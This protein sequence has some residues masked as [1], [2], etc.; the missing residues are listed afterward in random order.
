MKNVHS[1]LR[2]FP[3][4]TRAGIRAALTG[5]LSFT[6]LL[7]LLPGA[8]LAYLDLSA[9][10]V[11]TLDNG[12]TVI[13][14][15]DHGFP[16][17]SVQMLYKS[18]ARD[19]ITGK[20][21]LAHFLEHMAFRSSRNF[22][23]TGVVSS[24]YAAGGEWHGY[25]WLDQTTYFATVP[26]EKL[27]L[28]LRI[29]ADRMTRLDIPLADM[30]SERGAVLTEM[31]SY[32]NDP[33]TVLQ[34]NVM[35]LSFLAHPY[36]N[37]TIGWES[38]IANITHADL[39]D[40]YHRHYQPANAV[41]AIVG[42]VQT[43]RVMQAVAQ[44]FAAIEGHAVQAASYTVEPAQKG[45]RR[46]RLKGE[47]DRKYFKIVYHA[48]GVNNPDYAAFLVT[49]DLLAAGSGVSFLQNDWGTPARAGS[50]LAGI[51]DDLSTWFPPSAQDYV[52][53][54]SGTLPANGDEHAAETAIEDG[55]ESLRREFSE[56]GTTAATALG[57]A[58]E[59]VTRELTFDL[60]TTEDA[61][62]QL[63]FFEGLDAL[64]VLVNLEKMVRQVSVEDIER[65]L[66]RY[67]PEQKR[68]VGWY[69]PTQGG[70]TTG[71]WAE[72]VAATPKTPWTGSAQDAEASRESAASPVLYTLANGTPVIIQ[73]S[74]LSP[75]AV[76]KVITP[77]ASFEL[78]DGASQGQPA[79]GLSS[80][81]FELLPAELE[82]AIRQARTTL[83]TAAPMEAQAGGAAT[84]PI[85]VLDNTFNAML[86]L[87]YPKAPARGPVLLVV[88]GD[89]DPTAVLGQLQR[90]FGD[91]TAT[92]WSPPP[93]IGI[94][95]PVEVEKYVDFPVAQEQ[96]GYLVQVPGPRDRTEPAWRMALYI[97]SH[98][99][100]GRLGKA[101]ISR[102][103][104]V[105]HIDSDW[106]TDGANDWITIR[107]GVD[108]QKLPAMKA[109]LRQELDRLIS[110]PPSAAEI[111]A[112]RSHLL[113]RFV[114]AAQSNG[115]LAAWLA[116]QW[117]LHGRLPDYEDL[118]RRL[119][120]VGRNDIVKML[121][122]FTSGSIVSVRNPPAETGE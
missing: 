103:G 29:E 60:Q 7:G 92:T 120:A 106:H 115:E 109:L 86:G 110:E 6:L 30:D 13:V 37:N 19:E 116:G 85:S 55:I 66:D 16:V 38:D 43:D 111:D 114:S 77:A 105:Y 68:T 83:E 93:A 122:A 32:E 24:I 71:P 63:A 108:P 104:L 53:M 90:G 84:D 94:L 97:L 21:G 25:T 31:H 41:L 34:D 89:I 69:V 47:V 78:P 27:D 119:D 101:A 46:I 40:F 70:E 91:M 44:N 76:F 88:T 121:P 35:Y 80:I 49:Q 36:R 11:E 8:A 51:G 100:E 57:K 17:V 1:R 64:G 33:A 4:H 23:D 62:H 81:D 117:I 98:G 118:K 9:A 56:A 79:W 12:L 95:A 54:I 42:D 65:V 22:P 28:L 82:R 5:L 59:R 15:E 10:R 99:Y 50:P 26:K 75:T 102:R 39:V 18:G 113:G 87:E 72:P 74:P 73:R 58:R 20:T 96:L 52:F 14:L 112:A 45:E 48:P 61:A 67:L 107:T 3:L 2:R